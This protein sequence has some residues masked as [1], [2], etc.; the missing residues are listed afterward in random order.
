MSYFYLIYIFSFILTYC[1]LNIKKKSYLW[2]F[3][4]SLSLLP[5]FILIITSFNYALKG[6]SDFSNKKANAIET[7]I[8]TL[9]IYLFY[10]W[11]IFITASILLIFSFTKRKI[12]DK[13]K[14][15]KLEKNITISLI[16]IS[17]IILIISFIV[18]IFK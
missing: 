5:F 16:I 13:T 18:L 15:T 1:I 3:L 17:I 10:Y 4:I 8:F 9:I 11:Y 14:L 7:G 2:N 6:F 12:K